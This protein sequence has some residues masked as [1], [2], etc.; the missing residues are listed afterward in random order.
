MTDLSLR[1]GIDSKDVRASR[2]LKFVCL[3]NCVVRMRQAGLM[4][5]ILQWL[6]ELC[7]V[8]CVFIGLLD[9]VNGLPTSGFVIVELST[10]MSCPRHRPAIYATVATESKVSLPTSTDLCCV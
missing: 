1:A 9:A 4:V 6:K 5:A 3:N 7:N 8:K 2:C 10:C